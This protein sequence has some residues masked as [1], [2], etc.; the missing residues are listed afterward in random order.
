MAWTMETNGTI[1]CWQSLD[2][3]DILFPETELPFGD[4]LK[5]RGG[6]PVCAP[7]FGTAPTDGPYQGIHLPKHG[8]VR[9]CRIV[10]GKQSAQNTCFHQSTPRLDEDG[11]LT[12]GFMFTHPWTHDVW[13][14]AEEDREPVDGKKLYLRHRILVGVKLI[15]DEGMPC[16]VG[17]HPY[18]ATAGNAFSL[19]YKDEKWSVNDL[20]V[21]EPFFVPHRYGEKFLIAT[22]HGDV[23]IELKTGYN[24]YY[25]WTDKPDSY[26]CVEPVSDG[27]HACYRMLR[28]GEALDCECILTYTPNN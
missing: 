20:V 5:L 4:K 28:A 21:D 10:D 1:S 13:V 8:L 17:F 2:G 3:T 9:D 25:V 7:N 18:F 11:W 22:S 26:V 23:E 14:S 15:E 27:G 6:A 16:S 24:G 19:F 12:T